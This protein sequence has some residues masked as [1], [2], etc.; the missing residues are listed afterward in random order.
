MNFDA[1]GADC[2]EAFVLKAFLNPTLRDYASSEDLD[3]HPE[4]N[5]S[6]FLI[7]GDIA[8]YRMM[9]GSLNWLITLGRYNVHHASVTLVRYMIIPKERHM[10]AM[11]HVF[12]Y[13]KSY[14]KFSIKFDTDLTDHSGYNVEKYD[15]FP[16]YEGDQEE[17]AHGMPTPKGK[18]VNTSGFFDASHAC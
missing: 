15:W 10:K 6:P 9:M 4:V 14:L 2:Q 17:M 11:Q 12:G 16:M 3:Y 13:L 1:F 8:K 18:P 5:E 7:G